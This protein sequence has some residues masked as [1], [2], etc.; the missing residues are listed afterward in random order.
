MGVAVRGSQLLD[1]WVGLLMWMGPLGCHHSATLA[2][3]HPLMTVTAGILEESEPS[4]IHDINLKKFAMGDKEPDLSN[5]RWAGEW[6]NGWVGGWVGG[7]VGGRARV[8]RW[9]ICWV[10]RRGVK[11]LSK[12]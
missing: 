11:N 8:S 1:V 6:V 3:L 7:R 5:I 4:W 9:L 10:D 2:A 12:R